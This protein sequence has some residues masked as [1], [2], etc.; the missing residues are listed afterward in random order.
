LVARGQCYADFVVRVGPGSGTFTNYATATYSGPAG[1]LEAT[2][3]IVTLEYNKY[4]S[5]L[6]ALIDTGD[7]TIASG[8]STNLD[9]YVRN[10]GPA[11]ESNYEVV[12]T[13]PSGTVVTPPSGC[14]A[15]GTTV[16]CDESAGTESSTDD[17]T[18]IAS[19]YVTITIP[20]V[21]PAN[22][23]VYDFAIAVTSSGNDASADN[24]G[25]SISLPSNSAAT[26]VQTFVAMPKNKKPKAKPVSV[27]TKRNTAIGIDV[28]SLISDPNYDEM[29]LKFTKPNKKQGSVTLSG[30]TFTFTPKKNFVGT[31]TFYYT[32]TDIKGAK[33]KKTK[34]T[35]R[36]T[37]TG[38][39]TTTVKRCFIRTGC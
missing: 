9:V 3:N 12:I 21:L 20:V 14:T 18:L 22:S 36:V 27:I 35:V 24:N 17:N 4:T 29:T 39:K 10:E 19:E 25:Q 26:S 15:S 33:S 31:S 23:S 7:D 34:V 6:I 13:V 2:S 32:V 30:N 38:K 5:D 11:P 28:T 8:G 16:T 37:K 1:A